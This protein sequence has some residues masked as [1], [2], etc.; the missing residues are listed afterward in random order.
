MKHWKSIKSNEKV[1]EIKTG[2]K[3]GKDDIYW[4]GSE[5][6]AAHRWL[7]KRALR[8]KKK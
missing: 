8:D 5:A 4:N 2:W 6:L 7:H 1:R 3:V